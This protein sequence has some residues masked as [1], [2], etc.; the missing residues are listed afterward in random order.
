VG[1]SRP[2]ETERKPEPRGWVLCR[3]FHW[4]LL[5]FGG[6]IGAVAGVAGATITDSKMGFP[7]WVDLTGV[8]GGFA[9]G[10]LV[11]GLILLVGRLRSAFSSN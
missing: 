6:T 1:L 3:P 10:V 5:V 7:A 9:T 11:T 8:L 2:I 4:R